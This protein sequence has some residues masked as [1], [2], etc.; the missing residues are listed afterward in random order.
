VLRTF[1]DYTEHFCSYNQFSEDPS[2]DLNLLLRRDFVFW[3]PNIQLEHCL[4]FCQIWKLYLLQVVEELD[5]SKL[6]RLFYH[7]LAGL[8]A[9]QLMHF[10]K[11]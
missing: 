8:R 9:R 10:F 6:D 3:V 4:N 2:A 5:N 11:K 7:N 1:L